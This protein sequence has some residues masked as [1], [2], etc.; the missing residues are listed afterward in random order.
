MIEID[1]RQLDSATLDNVLSE[2]VLRE[3]TDYGEQ[4]ISLDDKKQKILQLL[5]LGKVRITFDAKEG[6]CDLV[7][8]DHKV[9]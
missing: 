5:E 7:P 8:F 1:H 6:F 2:I 9:L 3:G 4:E